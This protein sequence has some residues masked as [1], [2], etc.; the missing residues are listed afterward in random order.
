MAFDPLSPEVVYALKGNVAY[1]VVGA[2]ASAIGT[3]A[4]NRMQ[5]AYTGLTITGAAA[6]IT[7]VKQ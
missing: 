3:L 4:Q 6:D 2:S 1:P 7:V 5:D